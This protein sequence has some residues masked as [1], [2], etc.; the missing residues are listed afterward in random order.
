MAVV[1]RLLSFVPDL[2]FLEGD[3]AY[4]VNPQSS[5]SPVYSYGQ[6]HL[7]SE[8][9][10]RK[11]ALAA[12]RVRVEG[13]DAGS[14]V[15]VDSFSWVEVG[16]IY[17]RLEQIEDRNIGSV[18]QAQARGEACLREAEIDSAGGVIRIPVNCGQ[19]LYDVIEINDPRA[20][21]SGVKRRVLG[22]GLSSVPLKGE[23]RQQIMLGAV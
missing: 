11:G 7:I 23:Y 21:L 20:G 14:P 4:L 9:R 3:K 18:A 19:Q 5:D 17:D 12:N 13:D 15:I 6:S 10:Y 22:L 2:L 1:R 8:G 16:R